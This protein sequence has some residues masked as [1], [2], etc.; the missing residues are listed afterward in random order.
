[1]QGPTAQAAAL[2]IFGND[3]L[4]GYQR[5]NFWPAATVFK[6][7]KAVRFVALG[8]E[9]AKPTEHPFAEDPMQ[10][11]SRLRD[12]GTISLRLHDV[13]RNDPRISD[14]MSV[15]FVGGGGRWVIETRQAQ[16]SDLWEARWQVMNKDDPDRK[17]WDVAYFRTFHGGA[18]IP[19]QPRS[20][21]ALRHD[22]SIVLAKIEAFAARQ[23]LEH[24]ANAFRNAAD[25]FSSAEPLAETY[26]SD[27]APTPAMPLEARQLLGAVLAS[28]VFGGMGSW[29][30]LGLDGNDQQE[31]MELSDELFALLNQAI[32]VAVNSTS[33]AASP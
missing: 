18:H 5:E 22:L 28:W 25:K 13:P 23:K 16:A 15:G 11:I 10:W 17:I 4:R 31:Y 2:V 33:E 26:H 6:F 9:P 8:G 3:I 21:G 27:L 7:C 30:D 29:N 14:R 24:F 20:L 1:M 32:A 12:E 19:L